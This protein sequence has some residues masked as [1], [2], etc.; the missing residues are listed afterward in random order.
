MS[1][2]TAKGYPYQFSIVSAVYKVEEY[3]EEYIESLLGQTLDFEH[4]VQLILV[5]D[6]SPD[7]SGAIC[8]RYAER[9]PN[10][11][12]VVHKEN[13]GVS[14]ARNA[15]LSLIEG[16]YVNFC[17]PDDKLAPNTLEAVYAFFEAHREETDVVSV[18]LELF[19]DET[20]THML[21]NKFE[22][23]DR[24]ISLNDELDCMQLMIA[25][26]FIRREAADRICF[27]TNLS[28]AEDAEQ[29]MQIFIKKPYLGVVASSRYFY[30]KRG[31]SA[32][33]TGSQKKKWYN[34]S[35]RYFSIAVMEDA[36][37]IYGYVPK[38]VQTVVAYELQWK[39]NVLEE[40]QTVLTKEEFSEFGALLR[41]A[42]AMIDDDIWF[43]QK[44]MAQEVKLRLLAA[45]Y[46]REELI[47]AEQNDIC[48]STK[49]FVF[50]RF[51]ENMTEYSF[52]EIG[53]D[54][55]SVSVR[56]TVQA[57]DH[58]ISAVYFAVG[59]TRVEGIQRGRITGR[60]C[61]G[62]PVFFWH[63]CDF[64]I[65]RSALTGK[66]EIVLH[67]VVDGVDVEM[68]NIVAGAY[69]GIE[70]RYRH[71]YYSRCGLF[72]RFNAHKLTVEPTG[73]FK[74]VRQELRFLWELWRSGDFGAKKAIV[75]RVLHWMTRP[76][77][78]RKV[79][80]LSD[81]LTKGGDNAEA[82]FRY[83]G[84]IGYQKAKCFFAIHKGSSYD[85]LARIGRVVEAGSWRYKLLYLRADVIISS[86]ADESVT[87]PFDYYSAPYRDLLCNK[88]IVFLQHGVTKDD[89]STWLNKYNKNIKGFV[90]AA[91][92]EHASIVNTPS[93]YYTE[94][95]VW[96][97][98][99]ARFDRLY[100]DSKKLL[101]IM[102]TWRR[103]LM[104]DMDRKTGIWIPCANFT[105]SDYFRFYNSLLNDERLLTAAEQYGYT[106]CYLPH[107]NTMTQID[108][109]QKDARVRF[110][111]VDAE[112]RE[113]YA[114]SDLILT[115]YSSAVFDFA[116]LRQPVVYAHFD[117]DTIFNGTHIGAKGY[118]DYERDGFGEVTYD[119]KS[120]VDVL[121]DYM[122]NGCTLKDV[123][124][125]R[126]DGFFAFDDQNNCK[127]ILEKIENME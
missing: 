108:L 54:M 25:S 18:P 6:G 88:K 98:G 52:L 101:T 86:H 123:Y 67:A 117:R 2:E 20:G 81:R 56:L 60:K 22:K 4:N 96:L 106:V 116:Y 49:D 45:R 13:G 59:D 76:F 109:F 89:I 92:P 23:G 113:V 55:L 40:P 64:M 90:C 63:V 58:T 34:D 111:G 41:R 110:F 102:P 115:D 100:R 12:K 112:Y 85:T 91:R 43:A 26:S 29:L 7:G 37:E 51:S 9:Y 74:R 104:V 24:V 61:Y 31:T 124:R 38:F 36:K 125:A 16:K 39:L 53:E 1:T 8:D 79:W 69:F 27:N 121:I 3:L 33:G 48:Y 21:N 44:Y 32:M 77:C 42:L 11:I 118:F 87:N 10:N 17:D 14:S 84:E 15:G 71:A 73:F 80:I 72:F 47:R 103:Y 46:P 57:V 122:K 66:T 62:T 95:E 93:Y 28:I 107:P 65:P 99:F 68:K 75:A 127:R 82:L 119:L 19:G 83:L 105:K 30:R 126:I 35:V 5:D 120:T 94:K 114:Q 78:R 97:T 70:P 50:H